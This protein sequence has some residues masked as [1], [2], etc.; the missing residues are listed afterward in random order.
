MI[1][2]FFINAAF[3][4]QN[5]SNHGAVTPLLS[6]DDKHQS[7]ASYVGTN[8]PFFEEE[9]TAEPTPVSKNAAFLAHFSHFC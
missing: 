7:P 4:I 1:A 8:L 2:K 3:E 9:Y 6:S 5:S